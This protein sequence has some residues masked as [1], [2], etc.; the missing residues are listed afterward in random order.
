MIISTLCNQYHSNAQ[1]WN[2]ST[3]R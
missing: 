1:F 3:Y 2:R